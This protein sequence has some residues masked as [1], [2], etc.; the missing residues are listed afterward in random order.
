MVLTECTGTSR[1]KCIRPPER[2]A[3]YC[4]RGVRPPSR[5]LVR[6]AL[7]ATRP[8]A[9]FR[10]PPRIRLVLLDDASWQQQVHDGASAR[11]EQVSAQ[12]MAACVRFGVTLSSLRHAVGI[13]ARCSA[14][15]GPM[16]STED[17][18]SGALRCRGLGGGQPHMGAD[19]GSDLDGIGQKCQGA[20]VGG[21]G[22]ESC[23]KPW[24]R[25]PPGGVLCICDRCGIQA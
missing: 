9:D 13:P 16:T 6:P 21:W 11:L 14:L 3:G 24:G 15:T 20:A 18:E 19:G 4:G 22:P 23:S 25:D 17:V 1:S 2:S 8:V 10:D 12:V 5:P 7:G